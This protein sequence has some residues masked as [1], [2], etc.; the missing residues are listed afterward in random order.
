VEVVGASNG[1]VDFC[2]GLKVAVFCV[3]VTAFYEKVILLFI[4]SGLAYFNDDSLCSLTIS[5]LKIK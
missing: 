1:W 2:I 5:L 3:K 4:S